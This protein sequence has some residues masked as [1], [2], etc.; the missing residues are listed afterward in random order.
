MGIIVVPLWTSQPWYPI[1]MSML[2]SEIIVLGPN[3]KLL[4]CPFIDSVHPMSK[5][6]KLA[7][8]VVSGKH[9]GEKTFQNVLLT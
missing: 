8:A 3:D 7:A 4:F 6:L 2:Q 9:L 5:T 1:F